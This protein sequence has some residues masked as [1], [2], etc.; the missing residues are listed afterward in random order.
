MKYSVNLMMPLTEQE[1]SVVALQLAEKMNIS[2]G[3]MM[4]LLTGEPGPLT[5]PIERDVAEKLVRLMRKLGV[6]VIMLSEPEPVSV[7]PQPHTL[8]K[9]V[10][11]SKAAAD[12]KPITAQNAG[13]STTISDRMEVR[14]VLENAFPEAKPK[15]ADVAPDVTLETKRPSFPFT[16]GLLSLL[17][18]GLMIA[19][20]A[21]YGIPP[22]G[23]ISAEVRRPMVA[24]LEAGVLAY[25]AGQLDEAVRIFEELAHAGNAAAQFELA[26]LHGDSGVQLDYDKSAYWLRQAAEQNYP[27]AQYHLGL[28]HYYGQGVEQSPLEAAKWLERAARQAVPE[29]QYR[30]GV[31]LLEGDGIE[32]D[33]NQ[34]RRW[35]QLASVQNVTE[36]TSYLTVLEARQPES[37]SV[38]E[39]GL[40]SENPVVTTDSNTTDSDATEATGLLTTDIALAPGEASVAEDNAE[41]EVTTLDAG[42]STEIT[43]GETSVAPTE[44]ADITT[45][46]AAEPHTTVNIAVLDFVGVSELSDLQDGQ[47]TSEVAASGVAENVTVAEADTPVNVFSLVTRAPALELQRS[48]LLAELDL[49]LRDDF[50]QTPLMYAISHGRSDIVPL[51]LDNGADVNAQSTS[52]W[53]AL[54]FAARDNPD[55]IPI[56]LDKG[57]NRDFVNQDGKRA[58]DIALE[59]HPSLAPMLHSN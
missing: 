37:A 12:A 18:I 9:G 30:L 53:T 38:A 49:N 13:S 5:K 32:A 27:L 25:Q 4:R 59:L 58:F 21:S 31:M 11:T 57:A 46:S 19:L 22:R 8:S 42:R 55:T 16:F 52:G 10:K 28:Y 24:T 41:P 56:L 20:G 14:I 23:M 15:T 2:I 35:L 51:L 44:T 3:K 48:L 45:D 7:A 40:A 1:A 6:S 36:A 50:G 34:A 47:A 17:A 29:A 39:N 43:A 26:W 33:V 54:M